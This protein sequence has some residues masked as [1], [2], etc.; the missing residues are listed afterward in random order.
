MRRDFS[1][2]WKKEIL[3]KYFDEKANESKKTDIGKIAEQKEFENEKEKAK[4]VMVML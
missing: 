2:G 1:K 3:K 4:Q